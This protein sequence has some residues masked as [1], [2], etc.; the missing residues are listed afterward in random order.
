[1]VKPV[2]RPVV[3]SV[4]VEELVLQV[5]PPLPS[6]NANESVPP[7]QICGLPTIGSSVCTVTVADTEQPV[8]GAVT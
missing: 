5:P 7:T 2:T 4:M 3:S 6:D 8:P 1:M